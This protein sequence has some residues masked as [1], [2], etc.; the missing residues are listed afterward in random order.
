[1][2]PIILALDTATQACSAAILVEDKIY[3]R[4]EETQRAHTHLILPMIDA[5]LTEAK[6]SLSDLHAIAVGRGPGSFT[7]VRIAISVAQG[8]AFALKLPVYPIST[9]AAL[10]WQIRANKCA[11][12]NITVIPALDARMSEVYTALYA[13]KKDHIV[14]LEREKV[15][16]PEVLQAMYENA[17]PGTFRIGSGWDL[18]ASTLTA[19]PHAKDI[20]FIAR[21]EWQQGFAGISAD[22]VLPVYLRDEVAQ[23]AIPK[24]PHI[25]TKA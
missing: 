6:L 10:A 22:Q 15:C 3:F 1:M 4:F 17:S 7:G 14:C 20:A 19:Y 21:S 24:S 13:L 18:S 9:L 8:L 12:E 2:K 23:K 25:L 16:S 11:D 5:L